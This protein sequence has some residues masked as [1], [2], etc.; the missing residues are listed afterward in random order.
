MLTGSI[1]YVG[2]PE[3]TAKELRGAAKAEGAEVIDFWH[4]QYLPNHFKSFAGAKYGYKKRT[5]KHRSRKRRIF[6]H[7]RDLEFSGDMK[8]KVSR[9]IRLSSTSKGARGV[10]RGPA[11][12]HM[13]LR[14]RNQ[15]D[16]AAELTAVVQSEVNTMAKRMDEGI[17][18]RLNAVKKKETKRF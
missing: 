6:G 11:Y 1:T 7:E 9:S 14:N 13:R 5:E 16:K 12:L 18:R 15:P 4:D 17:T 3:A 2:S 10:M 8:R